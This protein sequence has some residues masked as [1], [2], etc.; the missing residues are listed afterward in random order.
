MLL[1]L[2]HRRWSH[3]RTRRGSRGTRKYGVN[4]C[5]LTGETCLLTGEC[6]SLTGETGSLTGEAC[7]LDW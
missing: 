3:R 1:G 2:S 6:G 4:W 7:S 5:S